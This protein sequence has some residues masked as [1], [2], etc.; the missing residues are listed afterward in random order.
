MAAQTGQRRRRSSHGAEGGIAGS[1]DSSS[2]AAIEI[3]DR[4]SPLLDLQGVSGDAAAAAGRA[5]ASTTGAATP[6]Y[7]LSPRRWLLILLFG[8]SSLL[9][10]FIWISLA[11]VYVLAQDVY[12]ATSQ[13]INWVSLTFLV[14]YLPASLLSMILMERFGLRFNLL[15]GFALDCLCAG[16]KWSSLFMVNESSSAD[17]RQ[18]AYGVLLFGQCLG[19]LAQPM[20]LNLST[21]LSADFFGEKE[22]DLATVFFTMINVVGQ[23]LGSLLPPYLV[24]SQKDLQGMFLWTFV[25]TAV[26]LVVSFFALTDRPPSPPSAAAEAQWASRDA[27]RELQ[28]LSRRNE[29]L[30]ALKSVLRDSMLLLQ[31]RN[32]RYLLVGFSC[33]TGAAWS[34]LTV[35]GQLIQPCGYSP[36]VA[37]D[38]AASL[39]GVGVLA[40]FAVGPVLNRYRRYALAEKI[41]MT[42]SF[43]AVLFALAVNRRDS[44]ALIYLAW[45]CCGLTLQ[46][47]LPISLEL[48][49]ELSYPLSADSSAALLLT[50]ANL[51]GTALILGLGSLLTL[52]VS[53]ECSSVVT[54][55]AGLILGFMAVGVALTMPIRAVSKRSSSGTGAAGTGTGIASAKLSGIDATATGGSTKAMKELQDSG[56]VMASVDVAAD[57]AASASVAVDHVPPASLTSA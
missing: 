23:L 18:K 7:R 15:A 14:G 1:T 10:A 30:E 19:A 44:V 27:A 57:S 29:A 11:P 41:V 24:Q 20:L 47:L 12:A 35:Q 34:L 56:T 39:L 28:R 2:V 38:S 55:S 52:P 33:G 22:T 42:G 4:K 43:F 54:P 6:R 36:S 48:A 45:C 21:R 9:S 26:I 5:H 25:P 37:G 53:A 17:E 8:L 50:A 16:I 3:D 51:V 49:A 32:F 40:S 13:Q 46:P 31:D